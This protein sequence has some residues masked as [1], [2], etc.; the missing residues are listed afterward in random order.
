MGFLQRGAFTPPEADGDQWRVETAVIFCDEDGALYLVERGFCFDLASVPW[1]LRWAVDED[2]GVGASALH[3]KAYGGG[4]PGMTRREADSLFHRAL[5]AWGV[6][7]AKAW[8]M[9]KA[10]RRFGWVAWR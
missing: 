8:L 7:K 3:D 1:W 6:P 10:V 4:F 2:V 5:Q 9:Y